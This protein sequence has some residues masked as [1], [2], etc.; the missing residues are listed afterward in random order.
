MSNK[1]K[2][3]IKR[4]IKE[5]IDDR[6]HDVL[7]SRFKTIKELEDHIKSLKAEIKK[8]VDLKDNV[9]CKKLTIDGALRIANAVNKSSKAKYLDKQ[10]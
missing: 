8:L 10:K 9:Q 1:I 7:Y 6:H 4:N 5:V 3:Q 2:V